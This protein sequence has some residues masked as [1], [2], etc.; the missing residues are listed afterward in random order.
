MSPLIHLLCWL[1]LVATAASPAP[2][3]DL[4]P[5]SMATELAGLGPRVPGSPAHGAAREM[6]LGW[7]LEAGLEAVRV[8]V[9]PEAEELANVTGLLVGD[10]G[11]EILLSAHLDSVDGSPGAADDAAGCAVVLAAVARLSKLP[12]HHS[13]RVLLFD[14]EERRL[15]GSEAWFESL[16]PG[17]R[18]AILGLVNVDSVGW[19][20][21]TRGA[22]LLSLTD[23]GGSLRLPPGWLVHAVVKASRAVE[24]PVGVA[25]A[26]AS[27]LAQLLARTFQPTYLTDAEVMLR[28]GVPAVTLSESDLFVMDPLRHAETD[29]AERL[30]AVLLDRWIGRLTAVV[31]RLDALPG[32]PLADDQYL[33]LAGRVVSRRGLYWLCLAV[34]VALVFEGLP[35]EWRGRSAAERSR[36]GRAYLPGFTLRLLLLASI[37]MLPVFS[38]LLLLPA[39]LL[40]AVA[41]RLGV[42]WRWSLAGASLPWVLLL[43]GT[44]RLALVGRLGELALGLPAGLLLMTSFG[45]MLWTLASG[46]KL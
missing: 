6:L 3:Q 8:L 44:V 28:G 42:P 38:T 1:L 16:S 29:V 45:A 14:G 27:P 36:K 46:R 23:R 13:V 39:A 24:S 35:G 26:R 9:L 12:R 17:E 21:E 34:W 2:A 33:M 25:A 30:E 11:S 37:L 32:R 22:A 31:R 19:N 43:A 10:S 4:D 18:K 15:A 20:P 41:P 7:M 5:L 40:C